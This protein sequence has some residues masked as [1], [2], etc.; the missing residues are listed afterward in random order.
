MPA[1]T[2]TLT[3]ASKNGT[4]ARA[5]Q[6]VLYARVSSKDQEKEGFSIPAQLRLLRDYATNKDFVIAQEFTDVETAKASGRTNF[7]EM[8]MYLKKHQTKCRTILVEKTDRLYRNIKDYAIIDEFDVEVHFV[9]ENEITSRSSRSNEQFVHGIK[10]LMARNY[11]QNLGEETVKGMTEKA[12]AG[13]YPS[14]APV[15]YRNADGPSGK[16]V[17][18]SDADAAPTITELFG[19]FATGRYSL[20]ALVKEANGEGLKL[21]G[22]KLYS[23]VVHQVL[24]KR[25]YTGDF[26]WDGRTYTGS[27]EPLVTSECWQRVQTLLD[28]RAENRTRKVKHEFAYTGLV[29]C[30]HCGCLFVGELKKR[31]YVYY[32]CTGNRGKCEEPYTRQEILAREFAEVLQELV[33]PPAILEWL[34]SDVLTSDQTEQAAR[35]QAIKKLQARHEQIQARIETMY[36]DKLDG[37]ITQ[38]FFDKQSAAWRL[39][40]DGLQRKIRDVQKATLAPIDYAI[41]MLRLTSRA[42]ELFLQQP[43]V[44]QRR[45]LQVVVEKAAWQDGA[46]RTTLFEPFEILRHSNQ[47]S[48]RKE[49]GNGGSGRDLEIWLPERDADPN[50]R[51]ENVDGVVFS[52]GVNQRTICQSKERLRREEQNGP[53]QL[54]PHNSKY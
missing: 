49:K 44:E 11:S 4:A 28:A 13:I 29:H 39:E 26:D 23:S 34:G 5:I 53:R 12:C 24:R 22:R 50:T 3:P 1:R 2:L 31:K 43:A 25:L 41:D 8:L 52:G 54:G 37:R 6:V 30:G 47:E 21:R 35:A 16:R 15:G 36:L 33:I 20:K 45:L 40:Q 51:L 46:L 32:H 7:N 48:Y 18:V 38:E 17:I 27:H 19:R 9:K 42:S 10:V 14:C